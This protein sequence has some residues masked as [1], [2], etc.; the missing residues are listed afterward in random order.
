MCILLLSKS[1]YF[2]QVYLKPKCLIPMTLPEWTTHSTKEAETWPDHFLERM[3]AF[4]KSN[5][6]EIES[7]RRNSK[8]ETPIKIYLSGDTCFDAF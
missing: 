8:T 2:V 6:I 5:E 7:N 1:L 3:E 4:I